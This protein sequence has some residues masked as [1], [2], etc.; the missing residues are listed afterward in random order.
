[1]LKTRSS[2][3]TRLSV[4]AK[5]IVCVCFVFLVIGLND[6]ASGVLIASIQ[7][8]YDVDKAT[9]ALTFLCGTTGFLIAALTSGPLRELLG[10]RRLLLL[11]M[12][13]F[14]LGLAGLSLLPPFALFTLLLVPIGCGSGILEAVLNASIASLPRRTVLLTYLHASYG[15]GALLGPTFVSTWL[16]IGLPWNTVYTCWWVLGLLVLLGL[17]LTFKMPLNGSKMEETKGE[18]NVLVA[19]LHLPIAWIAALFLLLYV[20]LEVSLGSWCYSYLIEGRRLS[21]LLGGWANSGY[22]LGLVLGRMLL[23]GFIE[24]VGEKRAIQSC[25]IGVVIGLLVAWLL[26]INIV[27]AIAFCWVGFCLGPIF[28]TIISLMAKYLSSRLLSS[29]IGFM[30]SVGSMGAAFFPWLA[31]NLIQHF[32]LSVLMPYAMMVAFLM[33]GSWLALQTHPQA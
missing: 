20:G 6:A 5:Q 18:G 27:V 10:T 26:P 7:A 14:L 2:T 19:T 21:P 22:W 31:G 29:A 9:V 3:P 30:T 11:G 28:S 25:G 17:A 33:L 16:V 4:S 8:Q 23:G 15:I 1:M 13:F 24:R 12:V 32:S